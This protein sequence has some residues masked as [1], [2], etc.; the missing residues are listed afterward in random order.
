MGFGI[1]VLERAVRDE[2]LL[3]SSWYLT[4]NHS[5]IYNPL[6]SPLIALTWFSFGF[7]VQLLFG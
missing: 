5:C 7:S 2:D 4:A 6:I 1:T 3:G